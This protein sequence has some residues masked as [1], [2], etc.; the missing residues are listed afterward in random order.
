MNMTGIKFLLEGGQF[1]AALVPI[2]WAKRLIAEMEK[3]AVSDSISWSAPGKDPEWIIRSSSILAVH[4][5]NP[6]ELQQS[7]P[8]LQ[9]G[10]NNP[11]NRS[12]N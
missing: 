11:Y 3:D 12:G 10:A 7:V 9:R 2:E 4:L 8:P 5:F 6:Q 1:F